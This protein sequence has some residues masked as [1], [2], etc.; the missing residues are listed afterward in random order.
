MVQAAGAGGGTAGAEGYEQGV[1]MFGGWMV[2]AGIRQRG[3]VEDRL[4][5]PASSF[6]L[7]ASVK[8]CTHG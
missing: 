6:S 1:K 3:P 5:V 4:H 7:S 8:V 2:A